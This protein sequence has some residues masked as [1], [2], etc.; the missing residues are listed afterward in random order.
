M[1]RK[2]RSGANGRSVTRP[3]DLSMD[4]AFL[5]LGNIL[6]EIANDA[7]VGRLANATAK[8]RPLSPCQNEHGN[9]DRGTELFP[10]LRFRQRRAKDAERT[11]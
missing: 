2:K 7:E 9:D 1:V 8:E 4:C 10:P 5:H 11:P 3:N 6:A